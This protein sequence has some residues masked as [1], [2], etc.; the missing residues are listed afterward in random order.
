MIVQGQAFID[1]I[2]IDHFSRQYGVQNNFY[3]NKTNKH[4]MLD[5]HFEI[6]I[7]EGVGQSFWDGGSMS[8]CMDN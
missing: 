8:L 3:I 5:N 4:L 7:F 1:L 2:H 6:G